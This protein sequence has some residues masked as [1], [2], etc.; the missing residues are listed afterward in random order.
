M[1]FLLGSQRPLASWIQNETAIFES[2]KM[3]GRGKIVRR[4][5]EWLNLRGFGLAIDAHIGA[6]TKKKVQQFQELNDLVVTGVVSPETFEVLVSPLLESLAPIVP[7]EQTFPTLVFRYAQA[8]LR[9]HPR[10]VGG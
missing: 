9:Q 1:A 7:R 8:H 10:E 5:Q 2:V 3:G 4:I 6:V